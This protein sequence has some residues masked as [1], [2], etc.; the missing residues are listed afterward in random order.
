M[1][2]LRSPPEDCNQFVACGQTAHWRHWLAT[3]ATLARAHPDSKA[4]NE[5]KS[6]RIGN[7]TS[8][9]LGVEA[10][11]EALP[12]P[13]PAAGAPAPLLLIRL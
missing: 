4:R 1:H 7:R 10:A 8:S 2:L 13:P 5:R 3:I 6:S 9:R 12:L 11:L